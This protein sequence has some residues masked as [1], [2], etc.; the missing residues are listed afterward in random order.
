MATRKSI[1]VTS[2][3]DGFVYDEEVI[4]P[5]LEA[6]LVRHI[7]KLPLKEFEFH[8]YLGRRRVLSFGWHYDFA[9]GSL[10]TANAVPDFLLA[11]RESAAAFAGLR[12]S[13][14]PHILVTEYSPGTPM[15]WHRDKEVF[16]DIV[17]V[18]LLSSCQFRFR[19]RTPAAWERFTVTLEPRSMYLLRGPVRTQW[20]HSIPPVDALRYSI[21]F[22][23]L[24]IREL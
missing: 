22:R 17:G 21:T 13:D 19:R 6:D 1:R 12:A 14:F 16:E 11:V 10:N 5:E 3:P 15:G 8:G 2:P 23:S 20:E 4:L 7:E 18:S 9:D 24:R